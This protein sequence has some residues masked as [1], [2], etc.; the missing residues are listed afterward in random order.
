[1]DASNLGGNEWKTSNQGNS[2]KLFFLVN[3]KNM[4]AIR[5]YPRGKETL[6]KA[7]LLFFL[8]SFLPFFFLFL[9]SGLILIETKT[10]C[11]VLNFTLIL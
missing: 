4:T 7:F 5:F 10:F 3:W 8:S 2:I 11:K 1:M 6:V 9:N